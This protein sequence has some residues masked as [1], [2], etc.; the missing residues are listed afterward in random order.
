M[1]GCLLIT[2]YAATLSTN[3]MPG[4]FCT[5]LVLDFLLFSGPSDQSVLVI[6]LIYL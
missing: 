6:I 4:Y 1:F 2:D 3:M 5:V